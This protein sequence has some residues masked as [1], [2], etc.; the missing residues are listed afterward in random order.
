LAPLRDNQDSSVHCLAQ[1]SDIEDVARIFS[2]YSGDI[3]IAPVGQGNIND[4]YIV[5]TVEKKIILQRINSNVFPNP[6]KVAE[7]F[8]RISNYL[9]LR[10]PKKNRISFPEVIPTL[11][12]R[13]FF[14]DRDGDIWRAQRYIENTK[15]YEKLVLPERASQVGECLARFHNLVKD[16]PPAELDITLPGF[17][18]LPLYLKK[19]DEAVKGYCREI[20]DKL[21]FCLNFVEENR[22]HAHILERLKDKG[23]IAISV[24]HGDPKVSNILFDL[25]SNKALTL[26]DFDTVGPGLILYDIGDCLRSCCCSI[27]E[28]EYGKAPVRCELGMVIGML[29]GYFSENDISSS[30]KSHI[31]NSLYLITFELGLRFLTDYLLGNR[32][33]KITHK[34]ENLHRALVQFELVT[35]I[36]QQQDDI[37]KIVQQTSK[38]AMKHR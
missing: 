10:I 26:I 20:S 22:I 9:I 36:C 1:T 27:D 4:T 21:Q 32:Y 34:Y 16:M 3:T 8:G 11:S 37:Q 30:E 6:K 24:T 18:N 29:Q 2:D 28:N 33:F 7:N 19:Y 35:S 14:K 15:V 12:G 5:D 23:E 25:D 31:F 38:K 13:H 17:H